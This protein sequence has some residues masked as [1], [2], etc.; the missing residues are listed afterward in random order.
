M[1][2]VLL[3]ASSDELCP[4]FSLAGEVASLAGG[5]DWVGDRVD[6]EDASDVGLEI[7]EETIEDV[8][9]TVSDV[10]SEDDVLD[11]VD[12]SGVTVTLGTATIVGSF[13]SVSTVAFAPQA[14]YEKPPSKLPAR[15]TVE[16]NCVSAL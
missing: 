13:S 2:P 15:I 5:A 16:Q 3:G 11:E 1:A 7:G 4:F 6:A 12:G 14:M 10:G 8:E 9:A